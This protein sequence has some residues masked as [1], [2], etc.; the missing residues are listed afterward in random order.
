MVLFVWIVNFV[1]KKKI[2]GWVAE[3]NKHF[4]CLK[5]WDKYFEYWK[6]SILE[7]SSSLSSKRS[8]MIERYP[9]SKYANAFG[10]DMFIS[11][12]SNSGSTISDSH[13][14]PDYKVGYISLY[15]LFFPH[16]GFWLSDKKKVIWKKYVIFLAVLGA[17]PEHARAGQGQW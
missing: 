13:E 5:F 12:P 3:A 9:P 10:A 11:P 2:R 1:K 6:I 17:K 8:M 15:I 4:A 16:L 14:P 7:R